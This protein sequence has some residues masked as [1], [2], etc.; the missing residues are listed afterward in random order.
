MRLFEILLGIIIAGLVLYF[1]LPD[2]GFKSRRKRRQ[3]IAR[4]NGILAE[5]VSTPAIST[6]R[7]QA[8]SPT[9]VKPPAPPSP[10]LSLSQGYHEPTWHHER[11]YGFYRQYVAPHGKVL[12]HAGHQGSIMALLDLLDRYGDC[13]S[14]VKV[15]DDTEYQQTRNS[16]NL[17]AQI[18]LLDHSLNVAEQM[19]Q[20]ATN[21][22][23]GDTEFLMGKILVASL[24]HD[25]GKIPQLIG[26][27]KYSKG[28]HPYLSYL[29]LKMGIFTEK[30]PQQKQILQAVREHHYPVKEG[31]SF[32]LRKADQA[33]REMETEQLS[34][35]GKATSGLVRM[36]QE[37]KASEAQELEEKNPSKQK[38]T[39]P[40]PVDLSWLTPD[41]FLSAVESRINVEKDGR[42]QAFSMQ[43]GLVYLM[44]S[45]VVEIVLQLAEKHNRPGL[46][47]NADTKEKMISIENTVKDIL[48]K[49]DVIPSFIGKEYV[50]AKFAVS[51][52][53][54][55]RKSIG[56]YL[57]VKASAFK[58]PLRDLEKRK[59]NAPAIKKI[60]DVRPLIGKKK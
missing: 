55:N 49:K 50:G 46:L 1:C 11:L 18:S 14:V 52:Q 27:Q 35:N 2:E 30:Q 33:A 10:S 58:T 6:S 45:L 7:S 37:Q 60:S 44:L 51:A 53:N 39:S 56:F 40:E 16:Y 24:G 5:T 31:F 38:R 48:A 20:D 22:K 26:T 34:L 3:G 42:F 59:K 12:E 41:E 25:I 32:D 4:M 9:S 15:D 8:P 21:T 13:P 19:I 29:V 57:P 43:N 47:V 17:L 54:R 36:I 23:S 28:D